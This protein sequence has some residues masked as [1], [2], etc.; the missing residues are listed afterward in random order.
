MTAAWHLGP[1]TG[2]ELWRV[3]VTSPEI[4]VFLFFMIT[5]PR[6]IPSSDAWTARVRGLGRIPRGAAD[7]PVDDRVRA[8]GRGARSAGDRLRGAAPPRCWLAERRADGASAAWRSSAAPPSRL[9]LGG[10][11]GGGRGERCWRSRGFPRAELDRCRR[12]LASAPRRPTSPSLASP[13][14]QPIDGAT[15]RRIARDLVDR[16]VGRRRQHSARAIATPRPTAP[17]ASWLAE[18]WGTI[19]AARGTTIDVATYDAEHVGIRLRASGRPRPASRR[20]DAYRDDPALDLRRLPERP[21]APR[22][23]AG[24]RP[25]VRAGHERRAATSCRQLPVSESPAPRGADVQPRSR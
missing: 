21:G 9:G 13:G 25:D 5:D 6:T 7:R 8:Q 4:L 20:R 3:L 18:L 12:A 14:L 2:W 23:A 17:R 22:R 24:R 16:P 15:A 10:A 1:I 11:R 19:D